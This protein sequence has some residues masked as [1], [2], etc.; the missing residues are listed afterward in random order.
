[1]KLRSFQKSTPMALLSAREAIMAYFRPH[2]RD[3]NL[4]EQQWRVLRALTSV[5]EITTT[6]L[7]EST[8]ILGPSLTRILRDL[9]DRKLIQRWTCPDDGRRSMV[10]ISKSGANLI[11]QVG[12]RSELIYAEI[13]HAFGHK[14]MEELHRLLNEFIEKTQ[15]ARPIIKKIMEQNAVRKTNNDV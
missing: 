14:N 8:V 15:S 7:A 13:T 9:E 2:L 4:T 6:D 3:Y 11:T 5:N 10:M 12:V 1:M